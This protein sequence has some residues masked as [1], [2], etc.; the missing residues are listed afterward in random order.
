MAENP[1]PVLP[2][3]TQMSLAHALAADL[4]EF[5][6]EGWVAYIESKTTSKMHHTPASETSIQHLRDAYESLTTNTKAVKRLCVLA[7][8]KKQENAV[9]L[10]KELMTMVSAL[11]KGK[12]DQMEEMLITEKNA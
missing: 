2:Q 12:G 4:S 8:Q 10:A 6:D 11:E 1:V 3:M 7:I 5:A 9:A